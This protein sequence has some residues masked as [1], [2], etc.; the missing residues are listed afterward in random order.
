MRYNGDLTQHGKPHAVRARD[1]QP[2][3]R[4]GQAGPWGDGEAV[5]P[6]K[7][8]NSGGGKGP[9]FKV[10]VKKGRQPGDWREPKTSTTVGK[11]QTALHTK[12]KNSPDYRFYALYDKLY[13]TDILAFAYDRCLS[14]HGRG[15][16]RRAFEDIETYGEDGGWTNWRKNSR[17]ERIDPSRS[18]ACTYPKGPMA[19]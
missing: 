5:V 10:S 4:E 9:Q 6:T 12:A 7:P 18:E 13:R 17:S 3:A 2:D 8:G 14:N 16:R 1:P 15:G 19:N 11:L